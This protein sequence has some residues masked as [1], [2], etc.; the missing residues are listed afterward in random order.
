MAGKV[1]WSKREHLDG[2][3]NPLN[4]NPFAS[5][6]TTEIEITYEERSIVKDASIQGISESNPGAPSDQYAVDIHALPHRDTNSYPMRRMISLTREVAQSETNPEAWLYARVAILF[7]I[8]MVI[9]WVP[10]SVNRIWQMANPKALN[11]ALNYTE[12]LVLSLQGVWNV[13]VYVI[14]SQ[15]ACKSLMYRM[16]SRSSRG[17]ARLPSG[18]P[19]RYPSGS[20]QRL[21]SISSNGRRN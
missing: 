4:E 16:F 18:T 1:I 20:K 3:L 14:T 6:V 11:F 2:F 17:K 9:T 7:F 8:A 12:S 21:E 5:T 19:E 13:I 10:S 15:A